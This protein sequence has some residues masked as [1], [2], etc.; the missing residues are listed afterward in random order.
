MET[1][2]LANSSLFKGLP[3]VSLIGYMHVYPQAGEVQLK[4]QCAKAQVH[5][6]HWTA[7]TRMGAAR[8]ST[9]GSNSTCLAYNIGIYS[10]ITFI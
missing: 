6:Q 9:G 10:T 8:G 3:K 4:P 1:C 5:V 7:L 2:Q